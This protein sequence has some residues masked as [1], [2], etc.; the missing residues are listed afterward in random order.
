MEG[1][2]AFSNL[3]NTIKDFFTVTILFAFPWQP[4][5]LHVRILKNSSLPITIQVTYKQNGSDGQN[6]TTIGFMC[7]NNVCA[8]ALIHYFAVPCKT[9]TSLL[10]A[11]CLLELQ[12]HTNLMAAEQM[13]KYNWKKN[14]LP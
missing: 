9:T 13:Q 11:G 4:L 6:F 5:T 7:E 2:D 10:L 8:R 1:Y 14:I 12:E 3:S